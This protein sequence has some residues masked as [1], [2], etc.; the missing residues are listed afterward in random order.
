MVFACLRAVIGIALL[1]AAVVRTVSGKGNVGMRV[2]RTRN[3]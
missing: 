2:D 3:A 1:I